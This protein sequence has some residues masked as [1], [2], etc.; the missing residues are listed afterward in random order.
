MGL[1]LLIAGVGEAAM[2]GKLGLE[3]GLLLRGG[4][5]RGGKVGVAEGVG[6]GGVGVAR[7]GL[8]DTPTARFGW[9]VGLDA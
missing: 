3:D 7:V 1:G 8:G 4:G 6:T 5:G 9:G 2:G